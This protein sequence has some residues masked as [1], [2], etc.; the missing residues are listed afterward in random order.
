MEGPPAGLKSEVA[1]A[2]IN[3]PPAGDVRTRNWIG[4]TP[5][6]GA[7]ALP[8]ELSASVDDTE[9]FPSAARPTERQRASLPTLPR[10]N[11]GQPKRSGR[12]S[13]AMVRSPVD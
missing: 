3:A 10:A 8:A 6:Y 2:V 1:C 5:V 7:N 13:R 11:S 12:S 4:S 9:T